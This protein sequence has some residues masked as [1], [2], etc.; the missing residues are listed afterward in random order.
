MTT[1]RLEDLFTPKRDDTPTVEDV[2]MDGPLVTA[3]PY[4]C[5]RVDLKCGEC[6]ALMKLRSPSKKYPTRPFY[7]CSR[8]PECR[9]THGAHADGR[10][11]GIPANKETKLARIRVHKVFDLIWKNRYLTRPQAYAWMRRRLGFTSTEAHIGQFTAEECEELRLAVLDGFPALKTAWDRL[12][13]EK[14]P[15]EDVDVDWDEEP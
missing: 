9:G 1:V 10:P 4:P 11:L 12:V 6:G 14:D 5:A 13:E 8:F 2:S 15:Y 7:G 3:P